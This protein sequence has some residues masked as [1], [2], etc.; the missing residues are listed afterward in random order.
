[1]N[2][3]DHDGYILLY[4]S[5]LLDMTSGMIMIMI[6]IMIIYVHPLRSGCEMMHKV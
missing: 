1:M 5:F 3:M 2:W 6:M 4:S